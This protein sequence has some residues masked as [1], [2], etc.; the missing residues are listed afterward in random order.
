MFAALRLALLTAALGLACCASSAHAEGSVDVNTGTNPALIRHILTITTTSLSPPYTVLRVYA[1]AGERIEM[2]SSAMGLGGQA[3]IIVYPPGSSFGTSTGGIAPLA[4]NFPFATPI[5][6]CNTDSSTP[7]R[8]VLN[9]RAKELAGPGGPTGYT[10]CS[11]T[12]PTSGIYAVILFS[13]DPTNQSGVANGTLASPNVSATQKTYL[14]IWDVTVVKPDGSRAP[15]RVFTNIIGLRAYNNDNP[16]APGMANFHGYVLTGTGYVYEFTFF[17]HSGINWN[18]LSDSRGLY[19]RGTGK[20]VYASFNYQDPPTGTHHSE[21]ALS[22]GSDPDQAID[23]RYPI[24]FN[25]P[26]PVVISGPGG[27]GATEHIPAVP[28]SPS[29]TRPSAVAFVGEGPAGGPGQTT[30]GYGGTLSFSS[31]AALNGLTFDVG[32]DLDGNGSFGDSGDFVSR[33]NQLRD[34]GNVV[35]WDGKTGGGDLPACGTY[36]AHVDVPLSDVHFTQ[37]DVENSGGMRLQRRSLPSDPSLGDPLATSYEDTDP[38]KGLAVTNTSP[39]AA[40]PGISGPGFHA[41][42]AG[43]GDL[44]YIDTWNRLPTLQAPGTAVVVA[45][46]PPPQAPPRYDL[47]VRKTASNLRV[48][49]GTTFSYTLVVRNAGPDAAPADA[50]VADRVPELEEVVDVRSDRGTCGHT[51]NDV[52]CNV[53]ALPAGA[54]ATVTIRSRAI[55]TGV[56]QNLT[57]VG[58]SPPLSPP[59]PPIPLP[60]VPPGTAIDRLADN[61]ARA[62]VAVIVPSLGLSKS[63]A[64]QR[65]HRGGMTSFTLRVR[66]RSQNAVSNVLVCDRLSRQLRYVSSQPPSRPVARL[67]CWR[68]P[69]LGAARSRDIRVRARAVGSR[70]VAVSRAFATAPLARV[71]R[72]SGVVLI[73]PPVRFTG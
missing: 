11:F 67:R 35:Y 48:V 32:I 41:W 46:P 58:V 15:G 13:V 24:F 14:T 12:A 40:L 23:P 51:G 53:G 57:V 3:D 22:H 30:Q 9:S 56:S 70:P 65:V 52:V 34:S 2:G 7:G 50:I 25:E 73:V 44:D 4:R 54:D 6:D 10:P 62:R 16:P 71:A 29:T 39:V 42:T 26:D 37:S 28:L 68:I 38:F 1:N 8:G 72:A 17:N 5:F 27:L 66:N 18:L 49:V 55:Q 61:V 59:Q 33:G 63:V 20:P 69:S 64:P 47:S 19:E 60:D 45:C 21:V 43:S 31:P 36:Q